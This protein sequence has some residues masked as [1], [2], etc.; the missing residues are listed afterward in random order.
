MH[1]V[2]FPS[3]SNAGFALRKCERG[4]HFWL[5]L[6]REDKDMWEAKATANGAALDERNSS[7]PRVNSLSHKCG[8][9]MNA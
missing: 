3:G 6:C 4:A 5:I 1:C 8:S 7:R 2:I 9:A